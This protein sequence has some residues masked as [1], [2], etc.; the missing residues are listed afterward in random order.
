MRRREFIAGLGGA[1]AWPLAAR[2]QQNGVPTVG[3]LHAGTQV[4]ASRFL[5]AFRKGLSEMG[6][7]EGRNVAIEY[8]WAANQIDALRVL[9]ADLVHR[10]VSVMFT[11]GGSIAARAAKA[12][13]A[14]IPI[15]FFMGDDPVE[16]DIVG[17]LNHPGANI[18]GISFLNVAL[19]G[20]RL[21]LLQQMVPAASNF[22]ALLTNQSLI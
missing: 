12:E 20:K 8:R 4:S 2:A 13:T 3:F 1:A 22:A 21:S 17:S 18:T 6:F 7:V 11:T 16:A 5:P 10:R 9:A 14:A 19:T 15:V